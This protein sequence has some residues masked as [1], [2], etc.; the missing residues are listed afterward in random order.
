MGLKNQKQDPSRQSAGKPSRPILS[1]KST[2]VDNQLTR[3]PRVRSITDGNLK[4][5]LATPTRRV[6]IQ[7]TM[8]NHQNEETVVWQPSSQSRPEGEITF[9]FSSPLSP[10]TQSIPGF[11]PPISIAD[12][13]RGD[14][15]SNL[16]LR[17]KAH[18]TAISRR[19]SSCEPDWPSSVSKR[20]CQGD[21]IQYREAKSFGNRIQSDE[22]MLNNKSS[23][24]KNDDSILS[25]GGSHL[26]PTKQ[27]ELEQSECCSDDFDLFSDS[28]IDLDYIDK[29]ESQHL[30]ATQQ[31]SAFKSLAGTSTTPSLPIARPP[32]NKEEEENYFDSDDDDNLLLSDDLLPGELG[33]RQP[34]SFTPRHDV[35][36][37]SQN[38][39]Y[40]RLT[41]ENVFE[42]D[43][44]VNSRMAA[45]IRKEKRIQVLKDERSTDLMILLRDEWCESIIEKGDVIHV[46]GRFDCSGQCVIDRDEG[47]L[48]TNP[49]Y[50]VATTYVSQ[51]FDCRRRAILHQRVKAPVETNLAMIYG[52]ILHELF[53]MCMLESNFQYDF[54]DQVLETII[55]RHI[56]NLF[57][58]MEP[59][60]NVR[61]HVREKYSLIQN[62]ATKHFEVM[63]RAA[64]TTSSSNE[65]SIVNVLDCEE[66]I[67]SPMYGLKGSID[68]TV[69][70]RRSPESTRVSVAPFEIK[71][72]RMSG[73][74]SHRAQTILYTLMLSDRYDLEVIQGILYY[75]DYSET[76]CVPATRAEITGLIMGRNL[77]AQAMKSPSIIVP[78]TTRSQ[79]CKYCFASKACFVYYKAET[80]A[81][82]VSS[83]S[84]TNYSEETEHIGEAESRFLK[85]WDLLLSLEENNMSRFRHEI[86]KLSDTDRQEVGRCFASL[87]IVEIRQS[88]STEKINRYEYKFQKSE[89]ARIGSY[90]DSQ[91]NIGDPIV[92]SDNFGHLALAAGFLRAVGPDWIIVSVDRDF[93]SN[94]LSSQTSKSQITF[95]VDKDE[96]SNGLATVRYNIV[97]L[98]A[99][100]GDL[101]KRNLIVNLEAP[102]FRTTPLD[103]R[104]TQ[105]FSNLNP[106]QLSAVEKVLSAEDY[107]LIMGM[108]GTGKTTTLC[109]IIEALL[110]QKKTILLT[111][112]THTAVDNILLKIRDKCD[113]ILR[114][115]PIHKI[116]PEVQKFAVLQTNLPS[117]F[118]DLHKFYFDSPIVATTC[119]GINNAIFMKRRFDYCIVDE[120]SQITLPIC[121]GPLRVADKFVL[122]GDDYQ[123]SPLVRDKTAKSK[124]LDASLFKLLSDAHRN[125]VAALRSQYRMCADVMLLS[126]VLIYNGELKCGSEA[127][128]NRQLVVPDLDR[129]LAKMHVNGDCLE[130]CWLRDVLDESVRVMFVDTDKIPGTETVRGD[131]VQ[132][133][134]EA[135]LAALLAKTL[136]SSG[137][138]K[139]DIGIIS[140]YRGQLKLIAEKL[141]EEYQSIEMHTVD[142][143]QGRDKECI[144]MSLVRS[145]EQQQVGTL[146]TDWRR[147]NVTFT[148]A[149]SKLVIFGSRKTLQG[150]PVMHRFFK[151]VEEKG[152]LY[153]APAAAMRM[154]SH[155]SRSFNLNAESKEMNAN[156]REKRAV[157]R[158]D[159]LLNKRPIFQNIVNS[160]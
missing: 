100:D 129:G 61:K 35:R 11:E 56:E 60:E 109:Q 12:S 81:N 159:H 55:P 160:L 28:D 148:R 140:A 92:V 58:V 93:Q 113:N 44:F 54:L 22:A 64:N 119:L 51:S 31:N 103:L 114:L 80:G 144:L 104:I 5:V 4:S 110:Q 40:I 98:L 146:L 45:Q 123:L 68:M 6:K 124:G 30:V 57:F 33:G 7:E 127:V 126:N 13:K 66:H 149:R 74:I 122:V 76:I 96:F 151:L 88:S 75:L 21:Q 46:I 99:H 38:R 136:V 145:N 39:T 14:P 112:Y 72:G 16:L 90:L 1:A 37:L 102:I 115:G 82:S 133:E 65:I 94:K 17:Y 79:T 10:I 125:S 52:T 53:Q 86:W 85:H 134:V 142:K 120:A 19:A 121:I 8:V 73:I 97:Q 91:I 18:S 107:A 155:R 89:G 152:W 24:V 135:D 59:L 118:D 137:V 67:W 132:N 77:V 150:I 50:L 153:S 147:L 41:V 117:N 78:L 26:S 108:P 27:S 87:E 158:A 116:D 48:I 69:N 128:A 141:E 36:L 23:L 9:E 139:E 47:L 2:A 154:H 130:A 32:V 49:D 84:H 20:L 111:S 131:R 138:A 71:T 62:W 42:G 95:R 63:N 25:Q 157:V 156:R 34:Y 29:Q 15:V 70:I 105:K 83:L 3:K 143:F 101:R 106:D 43:Y